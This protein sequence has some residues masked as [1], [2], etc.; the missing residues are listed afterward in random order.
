[1]GDKTDGI[2]GDMG[3]ESS[4]FLP[5]KKIRTTGTA[6]TSQ[7]SIPSQG[8][9]D[10]QGGPA[11]YQLDF[12]AGLFFINL[13]ALLHKGRLGDAAAFPDEEVVI[14]LNRRRAEKNATI[15]HK[16]RKRAGS[17]AAAAKFRNIAVHRGSP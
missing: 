6:G 12:D 14:A 1:M 17:F 15:Q 16:K 4:L 5:G 8:G 7:V 13:C 9:S 10:A 11:P 2:P 3:E